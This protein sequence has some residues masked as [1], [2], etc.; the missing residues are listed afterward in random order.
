MQGT[1]AFEAKII[2]VKELM[3]GTINYDCNRL[4]TDLDLKE[5]SIVERVKLIET[6][7][8]R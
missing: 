1:D 3:I 8:K 7:L 5:K 4:L 6:K 2:G